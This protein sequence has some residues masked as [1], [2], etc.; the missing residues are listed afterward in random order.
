M[1]RAAVSAHGGGKMWIEVEGDELFPPNSSLVGLRFESDEAFQQALVFVWTHLDFYCEVDRESRRVVVGQVD[2]PRFR[3]ARLVFSEI[4]L[5]DSEGVGPEADTGQQQEAMR[6]A[7][8][9][10][11]ERLGWK[12]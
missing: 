9:R 5:I 11:I 7:L 8:Q 1:P 12:P 10:G 6:R 3:A 2:V 4:S